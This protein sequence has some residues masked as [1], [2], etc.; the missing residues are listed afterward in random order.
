MDPILPLA[1][2]IFYPSDPAELS[3]LIDTLLEKARSQAAGKGGGTPDG[4]SPLGIVTPHGAYDFTGTLMARAY[5][6]VEHLHPEWILLAGPVHLDQEPGVFLP[7][8]DRFRTPL[9]EVTVF[10]EGRE[11]L[12]DQPGFSP[13][14]EPF[15]EEPALE[16]QLPFIRHLFPGVPVLPLYLSGAGRKSEKAL[17]AG[18]RKL[19]LPPL[20]VI[21]SNLSPYEIPRLS[22]P[23]ARQF[24]HAV[25]Q[26]GFDPRRYPAEHFRPCGLTLL[27]GFWELFNGAVRM[28]L[29][30]WAS[31]RPNPEENQKCAY[32]GAFTLKGV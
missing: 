17:A 3:G 26:D 10:L 25:A 4:S 9:G 12:M 20:T 7:P 19:G 5:Q 14:R 16:L 11:V 8:E 29:I 23:R 30:D 27:G 32:Y 18:L 15:R 1:D 28:D 22:E 2:D 31:D 6:T 13:S 21:T 24:I